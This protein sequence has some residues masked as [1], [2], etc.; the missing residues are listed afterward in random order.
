MSG[1]E[2]CKKV[3]SNLYTSHITV[4]LLTAKANV[5]DQLEG[6]EFGA[7]DYITKPFNIDILIAKIKGL[8]DTRNK[9]KIKFSKLENIESDD[10]T[11]SNL[12][13]DF[14]N[15]A[16]TIV[17]KYYT[18]PTFDVDLFASEMFVSRSQLYSKLKAITNL[19]VNEFINTYRLKKAV[20]L[21]KS[22][23]KQIS[24]IAYAI[25]FNDP[26]YFSRIFKKFYNCSP[27]EFLIKNN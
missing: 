27:S 13:K 7:D 21:L 19:S 23:N 25:G 1:T 14:F 4:V 15:R 26:K 22:S 17:E 6:L 18:D 11:I 10:L 24:E 3:K 12:D 8:I 5:E 9:L 20:E 16:N 2:L